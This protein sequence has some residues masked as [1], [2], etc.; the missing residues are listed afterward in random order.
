MAP[1]VKRD[2]TAAMTRKTLT[3]LNV[4]LDRPQ[5]FIL[6]NKK[7]IAELITE[8]S[9]GMVR[10]DE[11]GGHDFVQM[12][13]DVAKITATTAEGYWVDYFPWM[14]HI[15][16]WV[17]FAQWKRDAMKWK[18]QYN[19]TRDYMF[20]VVKKQ[21]LNTRGEEIPP[22]FVRNT[23][24]EVYSQQDSKSEEELQN[25]EMAIKQSSFT[26][27]REIQ[28]K[29]WSEIDEVIGSKR[30]P[31]I[32]DKGFER[33]PYLEATIMEC[34]RWNP[35]VSSILAHLPIRD[36]IFRGYFIPKGTAVV[37]NAWQVSRDPRLYHEPTV[38]NPERFLKRNENDGSLA[39]DTSV[40]SPWEFVFGFG[41]RICPGRDLGFQAAWITAVFVLW[42][43]EIRAKD[44]MS[45][46]D[47]YK[48]TDEERFDH[49]SLS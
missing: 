23:L 45:M 13:L 12:H 22:S 49:A 24:R 8:I 43:F 40:L 15:P 30:F 19:L 3:F 32:E 25:D 46:E 2:Y 47:G 20:E 39:L 33:M 10:D 34:M 1:I 27:F 31:S 44:G 29:A 9:Y 14:K 36:D 41:R 21:L 17:P 28:A 18:K 48:A 11:E 4:L 42:A 16:P 37:G 7:I 26:L 6:E 5:N 38:F 35:P